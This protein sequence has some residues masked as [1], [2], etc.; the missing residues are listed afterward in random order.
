MCYM[1]NISN[2][3]NGQYL[4]G[5]EVSKNHN[6]IMKA[7]NAFQFFKEKY[8]T[9]HL[10]ILFRKQFTMLNLSEISLHLL[11]PDYL[12]KRIFLNTK[13]IFNDVVQ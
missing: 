3:T 12:F 13:Y 7:C 2:N 11:E 8:K 5:N 6:M 10:E 1:H 4:F 9:H